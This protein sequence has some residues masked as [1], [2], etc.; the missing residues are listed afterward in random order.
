M[1]FN[2]RLTKINL[3]R[4]NKNKNYDCII[5]GSSRAT[6]L[7][8]S[9]FKKNTCFNLALTA[10]KVEEFVKYA[11]YIKKEGAAPSKIYVG[12]DAFN[13]DP[14]TDFIKNAKVD[15][16]EFVLKP[17]LFSLQSLDF[18]YRTFFKKSPSPR[19]YNKNWE[20]EVFEDIPK[21]EPKFSDFTSQEKCTSYRT[22]YY[23]QLVDIF[24]K[25]EFVAYIP[26]ISAW[27]S[28]NR[29]YARGLTDCQLQRVYQVSKFFDVMYDFAYASPMTSKIENTY[30]GSHFYPKVNKQIAQVL[31][32]E[33]KSA[34]I[35][36]NK[37]SLK[38]YQNFHRTQLKKF[39]E[40]QGKIQLWKN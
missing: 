5:F 9:F 27:K 7:N 38:D 35:L 2:E 28:Y 39:L 26:P 32:G 17:Y 24:P 37:Y 23:K 13:F 22:K 21:Y 4:N 31:E 33:D 1:V 34:G 20:V 29:V 12:V 36:I 15:E 10:G 11:E 19:Y 40:E 16:P 3:Y 6:L 8:P 14:K 18:S 25:A 30:D